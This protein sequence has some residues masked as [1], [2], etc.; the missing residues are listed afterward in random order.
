LV[1]LVGIDVVVEDKLACKQ[2][3]KVLGTLEHKLELEPVHK[4]EPGLELHSKLVPVLEHILELVLDSIRAP[5][6]ALVLDSKRVPVLEHKQVLVP[7]S[8]QVLGL[9]PGSMLEPEQ[10]ST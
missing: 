7:G 6:L 10:D 8:K 2:F 4:L 1:V 5:V 3:G 9:E